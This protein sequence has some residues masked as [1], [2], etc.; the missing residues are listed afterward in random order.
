MNLGVTYLQPDFLL[1]FIYSVFVITRMH[2][3]SR[4]PGNCELQPCHSWLSRQTWGQRRKES[5]GCRQGARWVILPIPLVGFLERR[6]L[7][8]EGQDEDEAVGG[9]DFLFGTGEMMT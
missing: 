7:L 5:I 4:A 3:R 8:P 2:R 1:S 9:V 6:F